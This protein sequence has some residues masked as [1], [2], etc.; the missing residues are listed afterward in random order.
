MV[1]ERDK[2][3]GGG[4]IWGVVIIIIIYNHCKNDRLLWQDGELLQL[5][6]LKHV[7]VLE[8]IRMNPVSQV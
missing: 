5:P 6:V 4:A 1:E 2:Y 8:P 3:T 7:M